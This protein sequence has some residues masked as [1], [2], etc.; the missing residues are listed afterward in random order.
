MG[1]RH[2]HSSSVRRWRAGTGRS[3][4]AGPLQVRTFGSGQPVVLLLHGMAAAGNG[5]GAAFDRLGESVTALDSMLAALGLAG[6]PWSWPGFRWAARWCCGSRRALRPDA[7]SG[8]AVRRVSIT[9]AE[10]RRDSVPVHQD[11]RTR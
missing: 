4:Q 10:G 11:R 8:H 1:L 6:E 7:R 5:F 9:L 3:L 2:A